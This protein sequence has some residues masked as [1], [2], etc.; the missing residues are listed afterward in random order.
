MADRVARVRRFRV[1]LEA[2]GYVRMIVEGYDGLA[3]VVSEPGRGVVEWWVAPGR[4]AEA[5]QLARALAAEVGFQ[6]I[7]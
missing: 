2:I 1:P 5:D 7:G 6:E 3:V 4:E